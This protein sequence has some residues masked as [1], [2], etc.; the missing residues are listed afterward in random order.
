MGA[1]LFAMHCKMIASLNGLC[2]I[3]VS[4]LV[5]LAAQS[6]QVVAN[7]RVDLE[8]EIE[9]EMMRGGVGSLPGIKKRNGK[10]YFHG[11]EVIGIT[12]MDGDNPSIGKPLQSQPQAIASDDNTGSRST[13]NRRAHK[14]RK[15][16]RQ[17]KIS[18]YNK[19]VESGTKLNSLSAKAGQLSQELHRIKSDADSLLNQLP[20]EVVDQIKFGKRSER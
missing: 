6:G 19:L 1:V 18:N 2:I 12:S 15:P 8:R 5:F 14:N 13:L 16:L 20:A 10:L 11:E 7:R 17:E 3:L 9:D 4:V